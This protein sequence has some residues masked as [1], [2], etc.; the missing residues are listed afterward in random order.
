MTCTTSRR[1]FLKAAGMVAFP[2]ILPVRSEA[3]VAPSNR[4]TLGFIGTGDHGV[5]MNLKSFLQNP[6]AQAVIVCDV[7][8]D[9]MLGAQ[10]L[11]NQQYAQQQL[12]GMYKGCDA[13]QDWREVIART[14]VD[15]VVVSTPDHWHVLPSIA[16]ARAGKDVFCE[17]PLTLTVYE[18]RVLSDTMRQYGRVFQTASENRSKGNFLRAAELVRNGRIGKLHTIYTQLPVDP[19]ARSMQ[20]KPFTVEPVPE[21]FDYEMWQGPAP[22]AP[23]TKGRC[24]YHFRWIF[25]YSGGSLTDW[26]AHINDIAQWANNTEYAGPIR[27]EGEGIFPN[28]GLYNTAIAWKLTYQYANGVTLICTDGSPKIRME[29]SEGWI[30]CTWD[31]IEAS[32]REILH[33]EIGPGEIH[34]RTCPEHEQRDFLN[35]VKSRAATYAPAEIGHRTVT[36]SHIGNIAMKLGRKLRWDPETERFEKDD[37]ANRMLS[38][39]MREPWHL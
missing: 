28:E 22:D 7:D 23:Y 36:I 33:S 4:I 6:D 25:D 8:R 29:G 30:E 1:G 10:E 13:T 35:C 2:L 16:A 19:T 15:A 14:D 20:N 26:G 37:T 3:A 18:G 12:S 21:G 34:L 9:R 38:R 5:N 39:T 17:K 27:V 11:V 24:H 31:T 32:S